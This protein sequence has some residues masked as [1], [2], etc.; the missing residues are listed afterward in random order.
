MAR[1]LFIQIQNKAKIP[2]C[3]STGFEPLISEFEPCV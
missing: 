2:K 1:R 3:P